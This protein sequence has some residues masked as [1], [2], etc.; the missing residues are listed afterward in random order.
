MQFS[1]ELLQAK[2]LLLYKNRTAHP[3]RFRFF[4]I[5]SSP[6]IRETAESVR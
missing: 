1:P 6:L 4:L 2:R 3:V 5:W